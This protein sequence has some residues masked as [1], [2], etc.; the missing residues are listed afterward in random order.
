[1][2]VDDVEDVELELVLCVLVLVEVVLVVVVVLEV[3]L[4]TG[5][6]L[7]VSV[8]VPMPTALCVPGW[9]NSPTAN[10]RSIGEPC[11]RVINGSSG[12]APESVKG[13][14]HSAV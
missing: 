1:M 8:Y 13:R 12:V 5:G 4:L 14:K 11:T 7:R 10:P 3:V 2:L 9:L 6:W